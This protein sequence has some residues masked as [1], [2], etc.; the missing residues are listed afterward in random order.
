MVFLWV[1]V[2]A[3]TLS[4]Q[5]TATQI[6]SAKNVLEQVER[7]WS[8]LDIKYADAALEL[9]LLLYEADI[10]SSEK[11]KL[12]L[13]A[14]A[15]YRKLKGVH[16]AQYINA[17]KRLPRPKAQLFNLQL[18][19]W[20]AAAQSG[21][22]SEAYGQSMLELGLFYLNNKEVEGH[23]SCLLALQVLSDVLP[24]E[25]FEKALQRVS[26]KN[27]AV[28][29]YIK[30]QIHL[31]SFIQARFGNVEKAIAAAKPDNIAYEEALRNLSKK[32]I[33]NTDNQ[34]SN[35]QLYS[36]YAGLKKCLQFYEKSVGQES[37][38][39]KNVWNLFTPNM[40][41]FY[42]LERDFISALEGHETNSEAFLKL[43]KSFLRELGDASA[44]AAFTLYDVQNIFHRV[45]L[46]LENYHGGATSSIYLKV[47]EMS[48]DWNSN[49]FSLNLEDE[50]MRLEDVKDQLGAESLDYAIALFNYGLLQ[51]DYYDFDQAI[52][53]LVNAMQ[54]LRDL[55]KEKELT[56]IAEGKQ[57][58]ILPA[59]SL[60][61]NRYKK[62][63]PG[64]WGT[65]IA[66]ELRI[67]DQ[68][69]AENNSTTLSLALFQCAG[70]YLEAGILNF[71]AYDY[72]KQAM[73]LADFTKAPIV[74]D[75]LRGL[76]TAYP[77]ELPFILR[78]NLVN[79]FPLETI[80]YLLNPAINNVKDS[81]RYYKLQSIFADAYYFQ[82]S[83]PEGAFLA[84]ELYS[85]ILDQFENREGQSANYEALLK[86]ILKQLQ[87][88]N[89][90]S[91]EMASDLFERH[92]SFIS[93]QLNLSQASFRFA[94]LDYADWR[95]DNNQFTSAEP[96]YKDL[97]GWLLEQ[98]E[99]EKRR[100]QLGQIDY[101]LARIYRKTGRFQMAF[102][103][104][105]IAFDEIVGEENYLLLIACLDD[106]GLIMFE[107]N[108]F[109]Q[110]AD[111]FQSGLD[112][113]QI[114]QNAG[115]LNLRTVAP[116]AQLYAKLLRHRAN[117]YLAEFELD[118][119]AQAFGELLTFIQKSKLLDLEKDYSLQRDLALLYDKLGE[120]DSA[121]DYYEKAIKNLKDKGELAETYQSLGRFYQKRFQDSAASQAFENGLRID[122]EQ[123]EINY[124][125]LPEES[126]FLFLASIEDR[127]Q[128]FVRYVVESQ[129]SSLYVLLLEIQLKIKG[130]ALE[131][132]TNIR[133]VVAAS[134]NLR[135][136]ALYNEMQ[137]LRKKI[138]DASFLSE[139]DLKRKKI[140]IPTLQQAIRDKEAEITEFSKDLQQYFERENRQIDFEGLQKILPSDAAAI[141]FFIVETKNV[142]H[143]PEKVYY[144][145]LS[146]SEGSLPTVIRLCTEAQLQLVLES[147]IDAR[148]INYIT[149]DDESQYLYELIWEPME[150]YLKGIHQIHLCP[151]G[152]L[153]KVSF[154]TLQNS[155][156]AKK[157]LMDR[158]AIHYHLALRD[159]LIQE[160]LLRA[161]KSIDSSKV[162]IALVGAA[163]FSLDKA[164]I[165]QIARARRL[166]PRTV[167]LLSAA[168]AGIA[169]PS[170]F[171]QGSIPAFNY[172]P[173]TLKELR[174]IASLFEEKG[175][176][177]YKL[178]GADALEEEL[179]ALSQK[180]PTILHIAT[181][182]FFFP[183]PASKEIDLGAEHSKGEDFETHLS[184][185]DN[186]LFRSG[187]ALSGINRVWK[188]GKQISELADGIFTAYEVAG[189]NL[190]D[191]ELVVLSACETGTGEIDNNEGV[192]GLQRAFKTA[193][194]KKLIL[195]LWK[196]P[197]EQ[198]AELMLL[199]YQFYL[200]GITVHQAFEKAQ[201][202]MR[203][204]YKNPYYWAAFI[205]VE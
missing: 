23:D 146:R 40:Q 194:A 41:L 193:G 119:A 195:S 60:L 136:K 171:K 68:L 176:S 19:A 203:I 126:R 180:N 66:Q 35:V 12:S 102:E 100:F 178:E 189:M 199:F 72:C 43:F 96:L 201:Q 90:W 47:R 69:F 152:L 53:N 120:D 143:Q 95:Y 15:L 85:E 174:A 84:Y 31:E 148:R 192:L 51:I 93:Q 186:P 3:G 123:L 13:D 144:A 155:F 97:Q 164:D 151:S 29:D 52:T 168:N 37:L 48:D 154:K 122:L 67:A 32:I 104:Y 139:E 18:D 36:A 73:G 131:T 149:D 121:L 28:A 71:R 106:L 70:T 46:D 185:L 128:G 83:I 99:K 8:N 202:E 63:L 162:S 74:I 181:H 182:G 157:R 140:D 191:T 5:V 4:A 169:V 177:V 1:F 161:R 111:F 7:D 65:Y 170:T 101:K 17:L 125:N 153:C 16:A 89:R 129:D 42:Q 57:N 163:H 103:T 198:T 158:Y 88:E 54:L 197:D 175:W 58:P 98:S 44:A 165:I 27:L 25:N 64:N 117:V 55:D 45:E 38:G 137:L 39:Y 112:Y 2:A 10:N 81:V 115:E 183:K 190:F 113:F 179:L 166:N 142:K 138:S 196:V 22:S 20:D 116:D 160:P 173:G 24:K 188:G 49:A 86:R 76:L 204:R 124:R 159:L 150:A 184:H 127:I 132:T 91:I 34:L 77:D 62:Q 135:L 11:E 187:L 134:D 9:A 14:L 200:D 75:T 167:A 26:T 94:Q 61:F 92:L 107:L 56:A 133:N 50:R 109:Q 80:S 118:K 33:Y 30:L 79:Y 205:L 78:T 145:L 156:G 87:T 105:K 114:F 172:L 130:L 147:E 82:D 59:D 21:K 6:D 108:R 110:A 141:D